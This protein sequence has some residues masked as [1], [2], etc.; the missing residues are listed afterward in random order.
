MYVDPTGE[1]IGKLIAL[2]LL[3]ASTYVMIVSSIISGIEAD[4]EVVVSALNGK[5]DYGITDFLYIALE[6][7]SF[8][9]QTTSLMISMG[10]YKEKSKAGNVNV[11]FNAGRVGAELGYMGAGA[12]AY[13]VEIG[14]SQDYSVNGDNR[15]LYAG[16]NVGFGVELSLGKKKRISFSYGIGFTIDWE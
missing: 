8:A 13:L 3:V 10:L 2:G 6:T 1:Y 5:T 11:H 4:E 12:G 7:N 15:S 9:D 14:L 16:L